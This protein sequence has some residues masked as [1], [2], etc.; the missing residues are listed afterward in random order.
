M[1]GHALRREAMATPSRTDIAPLQRGKHAK[2][3]RQR[4]L[5][6]AATAVFAEHGY[7]AAT[8]RE[9]AERAGCS[10][11]LIHR[12]FMGKHGL[13]LAIMQSKAAGVLEDLGSGLP[14]RDTVEAEIEQILL[15]HLTCLWDYSDFISVAVSRATIDPDIGRTVGESINKQRVNLVLDRLRRHREAGRI[16]DNVDLEAVAEVVAGIGLML[17]FFSQVVF[18]MDRERVQHIAVESAAALSRGIAAETAVQ[19]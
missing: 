12:Y 9:V 16:R 15:W 18:G 2:D 13:L 5:I 14:D 6:E 17:G 7:D 8:T 4:A 3:Q 1:D 19:A 11:G 10:E